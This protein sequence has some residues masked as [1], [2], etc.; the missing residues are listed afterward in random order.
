LLR[1]LESERRRAGRWAF[2]APSIGERD[3]MGAGHQHEHGQNAREHVISD[4]RQTARPA[5]L[6]NSGANSK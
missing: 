1:H 6:A 2:I 3:G 5:T 4:P